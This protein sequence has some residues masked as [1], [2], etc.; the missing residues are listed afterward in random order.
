MANLRIA[1]LDFDTIKSNLKT[2][3]KAQTEFTDYDFEGSALST[4]IDLLAYN[5]HYN[6]YLANMLVNEMFLD[7][8]VKRA[9]AVSIAKH[10]GYT[11]RSVRGATAYIDVQ[12]NNPTGSPDTL[13]MERYTPFTTVVNGVSL[14][15]MNISPLTIS[16]SGGAYIFNDV[17]LREGQQ[18][19]YRYTSANPGPSEK[20][21]IPT[22]NIDTTTLR[23]IVQ[24][25]AADA[26]QTVYSLY[27]DL[28]IIESDSVIYYIEENANGRYQIFFGDNVIGK[29]LT[30]GNIVII[31][32]LISNG[33][34]GNVSNLINQSFTLTG[35]I[36]GNSDVTI[37]VNEN[38]TGGGPKE[39]LSEIK[40][41]APRQ[42]TT[43][44][45]AVTSE[46]YK[47]L[48]LNNYP[49]AESVA[50]WGGEDND[51]PI[52]GKVIIS[53][54][55]YQGYVIS[56][57]TKESIKLDI[58]ASKKVMGIQIDFV[59][60]DYYYVH[61]EVN[62]KYN[63]RNTTLSKAEIQNLVRTT[64]QNYFSTNLQKF[65]AD[66]Y[67]SKL[68]TAIDN[69]NSSITGTL[70]TLSLQKRLDPTLN[71]SNSYTGTNALRFNNKLHPSGLKSTRFNIIFNSVVTPVVFEDVPNN[72]PI[73]YNG[74]G[75]LRLVDPVTNTVIISNA[76]SINYATG[77][78]YLS[79]FVP[80]GYPSG[81]FDI[82]ITAELQEA[83]YDI[84]ANREQIIVIDDSTLDSNANRLAGL[85][86]NITDVAL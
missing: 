12:V 86:I 44:N 18:F 36:Q 82:R 52:Y 11:P 51:P 48:I 15:F 42:Y 28:A 19:E 22:E 67:Y 63:S 30:A 10:L 61:M 20:F 78:V 59:D 2:Y 79:S 55:P 58:L 74:T 29:K 17:E 80:V 21:E 49:L 57:T 43:Q 46:D 76:G 34:D 13:T 85:N 56:N 70:M 31:Q 1:E 14:T 7:S 6:A 23:V 27:S 81:Q 66:F 53:L 33:S 77:L 62:V 37:T 3:L 73:N 39:T 4:L 72:N 25:S 65:D 47:T 71:I 5:T 75:T 9:S 83:S 16:P 69:S 54:K 32:Y 64:V 84:V 40:F 38:S 35:T 26:T 60:P 68:A 24:N 8:A 45:R 41:N 50:V